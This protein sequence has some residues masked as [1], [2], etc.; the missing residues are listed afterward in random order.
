[1]NAVLQVEG[2]RKRFGGFVALDGL[3]LD[4]AVGERVGLLGPNGS[5]K[6]TLVNCVAGTL[7]C[8]GGSIRLLGKSVNDMAPHRR[9]RLGL[10]RTFQIPRPYGSMSVLRNV[11]IPVEFRART[12]LDAAAVEARAMAALERVGMASLAR[13]QPRSLSQVDLRKLELARAIAL[14]P[15]LLIADEAMA[16]LS[17]SEV[18]EIV[19]LLLALNGEG[20][21]VLLIEHIMRA[22][23]RFSQRVVVLVS[24]RKLADGP[25]ADVMRDERVVKAYLGE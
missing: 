9:A 20:V 4:I 18:D 24:G 5:G 13:A 2:V 1:M 10:A 15:V 3:N 11:C 12:A 8:D 6:S 19:E 23:V 7:A 17:T 25:T 14:E 21:A 16:G 22:V